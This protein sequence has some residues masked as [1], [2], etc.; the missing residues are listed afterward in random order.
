MTALISS[1]L[2]YKAGKMLSLKDLKAL[3]YS[4]LCRLAHALARDI[5]NG[6]DKRHTLEQVFKAIRVQQ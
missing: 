1:F 4:T 2:D 3:P 6:A 5:D